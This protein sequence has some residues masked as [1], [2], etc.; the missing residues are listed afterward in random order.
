MRVNVYAEELPTERRTALVVKRAETGIEFRG[1]RIFLQSAPALHDTETDDDRSAI[2]FY[3]DPKE[4]AAL[5][6]E[7]ADKIEG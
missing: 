4:V 5:L 6:R 1:V 3:G 7:A 2:T